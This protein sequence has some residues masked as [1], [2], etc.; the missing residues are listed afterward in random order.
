[1]NFVEHNLNIRPITSGSVTIYRLDQMSGSD[2]N[3]L[4]DTLF[5]NDGNIEE[6]VELWLTN[7]GCEQHRDWLLGKLK[8]LGAA[9]EQQQQ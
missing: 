1:M 9:E 4:L 3:P 7:P 6:L 2:V 5:I 8:D